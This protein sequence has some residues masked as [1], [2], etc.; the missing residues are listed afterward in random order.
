MIQYLKSGKQIFEMQTV[1]SAISD[2]VIIII[3][4]GF[5]TILV[6]LYYIEYLWLHKITTAKNA[7]KIKSDDII[8]ELMNLN[9]INCGLVGYDTESTRHNLMIGLK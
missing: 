4:E 8:I 1:S 7:K 2:D 5:A 6:Y 9:S 3:Y